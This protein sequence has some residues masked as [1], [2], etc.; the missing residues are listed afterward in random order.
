M[1]VAR[2]NQDLMPSLFNELLDWNNWNNGLWSETR[3]TTPKMNVSE[4]DKNYELELCVP[5]L[6]KEDLNISID[7][8]NN[9]VVEMVQEEKSDD[10]QQKDSSRKYL[11][12]E[13]SRMQFKQM[14]TLPDNVKK[15]DIK[16]RVNDGILYIE[17]P[18]ITEQEKKSLS[19]TIQIN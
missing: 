13:F 15:D 2:R 8:D 4:T 5:G 12:R 17:L 1:L 19:Q 7:P 6:K 16:A 10:K 3:H 11:R 14:M 9:L 18:K